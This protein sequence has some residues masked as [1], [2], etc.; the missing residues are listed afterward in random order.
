MHHNFRMTVV[1]VWGIIIFRRLYFDILI[2][3]LAGDGESERE[4]SLLPS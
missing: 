2:R 3:V 4:R 1:F